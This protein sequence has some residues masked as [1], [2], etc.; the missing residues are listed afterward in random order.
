M[1]K[2]EQEFTFGSEAETVSAPEAR[3][4]D[5]AIIAGAMV[6]ISQVDLRLTEDEE[7]LVGK[8]IQL[9]NQA[10]DLT[11]KDQDSLTSVSKWYAFA[12]DALKNLEEQRKK[13]LVPLKKLVDVIGNAFK[14]P[15]DRLD[16]KAKQ[17]SFNIIQYKQKIEREQ[18]EEQTRVQ[19][20]VEE[21]ER[22][23]AKELEKQAKKE[24]KAGNVNTAA[25]LRAKAGESLVVPTVPPKAV[26]SSDVKTKTYWRYKV[27]GLAKVP[28]E[29]KAINPDLLGR[30]KIS[31][32]SPSFRSGLRWPMERG[33]KRRSPAARAALRSM[34][35]SNSRMKGRTDDHR[36]VHQIR[37]AGMEGCG[38]R[39]SL[40]ACPS[41]ESF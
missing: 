32:T 15:Y 2:T 29:Y 18:I 23:R 5:Q 4:A 8:V 31:S 28:D 26:M 9:D 27:M 37:P 3:K 12:K 40:H 16:I 24:E 17:A 11:I 20:E 41:G 38:S 7:A 22:A 21:R 1:T 33:F 19:R 6:R 39:L 14:N 10:T 13:K 35:L 34:A 36:R 25:T 30:T